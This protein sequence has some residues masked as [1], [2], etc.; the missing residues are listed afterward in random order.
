VE[1]PSITGHHSVW[2]LDSRLLSTGC[3][4]R[5][6]SSS[7]DRWRQDRV[8]R[9][10]RGHVTLI[11]L[12]TSPLD[13]LRRQRPPAASL[14]K[15]ST[16]AVQLNVSRNISWCSLITPFANADAYSQDRKRPSDGGG[17]VYLKLWS[18]PFL[19]FPIPSLPL[20]PL[21][22]SPWNPSAGSGANRICCI[23]AL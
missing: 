16:T 10:V 23:L 8:G 20:S 3:Q 9:Q 1:R 19:L 6:Y 18:D 2:T 13:P 22:S 17:V 5:R 4:R 12:F 14:R 11:N 7:V 21:K 15:V